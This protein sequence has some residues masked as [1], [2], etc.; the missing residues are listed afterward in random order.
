MEL[1]DILK[2]LEATRDPKGME[3][4]ARFGINVERAFGTRIPVLRKMAKEIGKD[5]NLARKLWEAGYRETRILASMVEEPSKVTPEQVDEWVR[6]FNSWEVC[7]Q[8]CM[9]L[10]DKLPFAYEKVFELAEREP[11]FEKRAAFALI[12]CLAWHD[13]EAPDSKFE[14]F[15][16]LIKEHSTDGR[17]YV[18]KAVNW[19]L[20]HIGKR[21]RTL[22]SKALETA[23]E[24]REIDSRAAS[25]IASDAIRELESKKVRERLEATG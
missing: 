9:N 4:M 6:D 12:A 23:Y 20:R 7:D 13:K 17:N 16:P 5:H 8:C 18:K 1:E 22:H 25:W 2:Q 10:F 14:R 21:N 11:E 3:G 19:A 24:I 15:L